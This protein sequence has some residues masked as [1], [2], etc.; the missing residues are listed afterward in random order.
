MNGKIKI[1]VSYAHADIMPRPG[2]NDSRVG[3]ILRDIKFDLRVADWGST[4]S[5]S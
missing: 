5:M 2:F 1:F 3:H 4:T